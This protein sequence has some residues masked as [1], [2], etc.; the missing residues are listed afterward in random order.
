MSIE[1]GKG[2]R[3]LALCKSIDQMPDHALGVMTDVNHLKCLCNNNHDSKITQE[4]GHTNH[5]MLKDMIN[6]NYQMIERQSQRG[7]EYSD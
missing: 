2:V 1:R 3:T 5:T 7:E 6:V 4:R